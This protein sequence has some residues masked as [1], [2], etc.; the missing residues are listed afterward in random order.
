MILD[1][2]LW[3]GALMILDGILWAWAP[4]HLAVQQEA[5]PAGWLLMAG[6]CETLGT[7]RCPTARQFQP[8]SVPPL[9]APC[10]KEAGTA[11]GGN[12]LF[13]RL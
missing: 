9:P 7:P 8:A 1:R 13:T 10:D 2:I 12:W 3:A 4:G 11:T 5:G 6:L